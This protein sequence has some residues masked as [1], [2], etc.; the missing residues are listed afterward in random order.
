MTMLELMEGG[1]ES[2]SSASSGSE[3]SESDAMVAGRAPAVPD[4]LL[5]DEP[6]IPGGPMSPFGSPDELAE[7]FEEFEGGAMVLRFEDGALEV[8]FAGGSVPS[9]AA[10]VGG[11]G[12][13]DLPTT[14]ALAFGMAI[15]DTAAE[16]L[17][18]GLTEAMGEKQ[19]E[20]V[21]AMAEQQTGLSL[22][23]D[24]QT[25]LGDG[26]SVA[27]DGSIDLESAFGMGGGD[28]RIPAGARIVGDPDEIVPLL[29]KLI[30]AAGAQD[31]V[32]VESGDGVVA[33]G[34]DAEHVAALAEDG[35]LGDEPQFESA[36]PDLEDRAGGLYVDFDA[37]DWL[38]R[39]AEQDAELR[40]N[41][42][43]LGS[44]GLTSWQ[45]GDV[46]HGKVRLTTD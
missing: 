3:A 31:Q 22:P 45:D 5:D 20:Q 10:G 36:L 2:T 28:P 44:L 35:G 19:T 25:L 33:F 42:E 18:E 27:V 17:V 38:T 6:L 1:M 37:G 32:V 14:T 41:L 29:E 40:D 21:L 46:L 12:M 30:A 16:D 7:A 15:S 13:A 24:L 26:L 39:V 11:S 43:P 23:E 8:E 34:L 9:E 4:E